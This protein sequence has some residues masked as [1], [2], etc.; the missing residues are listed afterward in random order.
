MFI[1]ETAEPIPLRGV[2]V[3]QRKIKLGWKCMVDLLKHPSLYS[4]S[5]FDRTFAFK[6]DMVTKF[7]LYSGIVLNH[8]DGWYTFR[9]T[10]HALGG[11]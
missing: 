8:K 10:K 9:D 7:C 6:S 3:K 11:H 2:P 5:L 1:V 4:Q